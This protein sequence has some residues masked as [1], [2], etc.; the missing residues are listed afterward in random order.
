MFAGGQVSLYPMTDGFVDV[1]LSSLSALDPYRD[2][3]RIETDDISTLIVGSPEVLFPA[4]RDLYV[5]TAATRHHAVLRATLSRGCPG[6]P[7]DPICQTNALANPSEPLASRQQAAL[8]ALAATSLTG[9]TARAQFSLYVM[10][11]GDHMAEIMGCIDFLKSSGTFDRSKNFCTRLI[12]DSGPV[13]A[14]LQEAFCR[15][16]PPQG[17][18]TIDLTVSAN[19]PSIA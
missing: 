12:G 5:A 14:T 2:R 8:A 7:D 11:A 3:L 19:S 6:E 1:I 13:F 16:G 18:V 15:F 17:H 9:E 4:L 10:G